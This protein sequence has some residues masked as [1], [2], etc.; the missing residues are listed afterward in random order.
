MISKKIIIV[1]DEALLAS[2]LR[3]QLEDFGYQVTAIVPSSEKCMQ[4]VAKNLPDLVLMDIRIKGELDGIETANQIKARYAIPVVYIT[5][6]ADESFLERAKIT[7]PFGYLIKPVEARELHSTMEIAL[8]KAKIDKERERL[9]RELSDALAQLEK[10]NKNLDQKVKERTDELESK[11]HRLSE[12]NSALNVLLEKRLEDKKQLEQSVL[13]NVQ[14]LI[15]PLIED[16]NRSGL[17]KIQKGY[18]DALE[19]F[20]KDIISPFSNTLNAHYQKLTPSE[21]RVANLIRQGRTTKEI[22]L[23]LNTTERAIKHHRRGIR[24]KLGLT[25]EKVNLTS[26]LATLT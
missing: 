5:A 24:D 25:H 12:V 15:Q 26:Y 1:E 19:S 23:L 16:L 2:D 6:Y 18:L 8:Y 4:Q 21:I 9:I 20:L 13:E 10:L 11:N 3:N 7:E 17:K 22:A 14:D